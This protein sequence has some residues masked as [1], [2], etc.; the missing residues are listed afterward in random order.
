MPGIYTADDLKG[1]HGIDER[2]SIENLRLGTQIVYE[3]ALRAAAR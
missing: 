2:L 1:F 3:I